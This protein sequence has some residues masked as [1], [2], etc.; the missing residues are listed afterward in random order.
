MKKK[1]KKN[2]KK[3]QKPYFDNHEK[4]LF[5]FNDI[6]GTFNT[7]L[8]IFL[9]FL[10]MLQ[11]LVDKSSTLC[12][13]VISVIV[14]NFFLFD[15]F[16]VSRCLQLRHFAV[17]CFQV[18]A[19]NSTTNK[20]PCNTVGKRIERMSLVNN[21]QLYLLDEAKQDWIKPST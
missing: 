12:W 7:Q 6:Y 1:K 19:T 17:I 20:T 8:L 11:N 3:T 2:K 14:R 9:E 21:Q 15:Q 13:H 18:I 4:L 10:S 16:P 5:C